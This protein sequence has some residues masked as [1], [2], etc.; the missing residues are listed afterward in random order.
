[1]FRIAPTSDEQTPVVIVHAV[2]ARSLSLTVQQR[3]AKH[4]EIQRVVH[5]HL[6]ENREHL[7]THLYCKLT[8]N[9]VFLDGGACASFFRQGGVACVLTAI[10]SNAG[11]T[12]R[13]QALPFP[14][15]KLGK[16]RS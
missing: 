10:H 8:A 9:P 1:M 12:K 2:P 15:T 11:D 7:Q 4:K 5:S 3:L 14:C 6:L 16:Q 13:H